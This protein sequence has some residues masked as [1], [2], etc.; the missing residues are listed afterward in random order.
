MNIKHCIVC[1]ILAVLITACAFCAGMNHAIRAMQ[2][3]TDGYGDSALITLHENVYLH[4]ING[5]SVD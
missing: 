4:G 1:A 2:I 3:E 5:F